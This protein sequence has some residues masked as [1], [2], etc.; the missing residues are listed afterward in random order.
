MIRSADV[1]FIEDENAIEQKNPETINCFPEKPIHDPENLDYDEHIDEIPI[2]TNADDEIENTVALRETS[3][4]IDRNIKNILRDP[5]NTKT[6]NTEPENTKTEN[7]K[8]DEI[9]NEP[10]HLKEILSMKRK[11]KEKKRNLRIK[12]E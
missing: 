5:E 1:I 12:R 2:E 7:T 8:T 11:N 10:E 6:E 9:E 4:K 3:T